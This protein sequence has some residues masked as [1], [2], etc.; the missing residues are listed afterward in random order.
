[1]CNVC[2]RDAED[3]ALTAEERFRR[4]QE[5]MRVRDAADRASQKAARRVK[6]LA[7][8]ERARAAAAGEDRTAGARLAGP[9]AADSGMSEGGNNSSSM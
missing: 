2:C 4:V 8:K 5:A 3:E 9:S 6:K 7:K 1:M